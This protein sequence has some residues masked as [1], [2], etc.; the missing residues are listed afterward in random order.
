MYYACN[1]GYLYAFGTGL[2]YTYLD[3]TLNPDVGWNELVAT[4]FDNGVAAASDTV[5]FYINPTGI[6]F[7]PSRKLLLTGSPNPF[8]LSTTLSFTLSEP[9]YTTIQIYDLSGR[10][11]SSPFDGL[12][13]EGCH[14][15]NWDGTDHY[16]KHVSEGVYL[17]RIVSDEVVETTGLCLL[18]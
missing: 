10:C 3:D 17:C 7:E 18:R 5:H 4:S 14:S 15:L 11:I 12:L 1:D 6:E 8:S 16:G 9:G 13:T 2:K